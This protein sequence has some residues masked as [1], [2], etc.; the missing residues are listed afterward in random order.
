MIIVTFNDPFINLNYMIYMFQYDSTYVK[1]K[2]KV[3]AE[4]GKL[5]INEKS[6]LTC[7]VRSPP[8]L[9][10][11]DAGAEYA[12]ESTGVFTTVGK[13]G[14]HL[15]GGAKRDNIS[16]LS[17]GAPMFMM[18]V[19]HDKY[20]NN[21]RKIV[22]NASYTTNFLSPPP[23]AANI[24]HDNFGIVEGFM[25]TVHA[26]TATQETADGTSGKLWRDGQGAAQNIIP[27]S[28]GTA[29]LWAGSSLS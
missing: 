20:V 18:G 22:S 4:N 13:A 10:E 12:V 15:K 1:F 29:K 26:I 3:K 25:T 28:T 7:G 27:A 21:S 23:P 24:I 5:V 17:A 11:G 8:T 14:A 9:N 6:N 2:G 19:N 16:V